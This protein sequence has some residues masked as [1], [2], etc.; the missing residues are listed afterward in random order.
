[1][2]TTDLDTETYTITVTRSVGRDGAVVIFVDG[3]FTSTGLRVIVNDND[4]YADPDYD[5]DGDTERDADTHTMT[6]RLPQ[7]NDDEDMTL[8]VDTRVP[9]HPR[10]VT[11][12]HLAADLD[13]HAEGA[14]ECSFPGCG[15]AVLGDGIHHGSATI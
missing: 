5:G 6:H 9:G 1:M 8:R 15:L 14:D 13:H 12:E 2:T 11:D 10:L 7:Y 4:V 3:D